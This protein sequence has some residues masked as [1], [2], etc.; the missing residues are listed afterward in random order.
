MKIGYDDLV[1]LL[2]KYKGCRILLT[3]LLFWQKGIIKIVNYELGQIFIFA[4]G[5]IIKFSDDPF[6]RKGEQ[7]TVI[8]IID[9]NYVKILESSDTGIKFEV[10]N[11]D[12][13]YEVYQ[14]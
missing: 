2:T 10:T 8:F 9:P 13:T 7:D 6:P 1:T 5:N 12:H 14:L 11:K 3:S 4:S